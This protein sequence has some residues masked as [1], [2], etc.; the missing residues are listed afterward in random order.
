[1]QPQQPTKVEAVGV[2]H[3]APAVGQCQIRKLLH[4]LVPEVLDFEL[5]AIVSVMPRV[6]ASAQHG[7]CPRLSVQ[8][9]IHLEPL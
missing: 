1:Q 6:Q 9:I 2:P 8:A 4:N 7:A 5:L 3:F